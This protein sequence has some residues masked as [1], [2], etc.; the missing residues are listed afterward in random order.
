MSSGNTLLGFGGLF[1]WIF[2]PESVFCTTL[3]IALSVLSL[4]IGVFL[5]YQFIFG[6]HQLVQ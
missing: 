4:K 5:I 3:A 2:T 6:L 1:L